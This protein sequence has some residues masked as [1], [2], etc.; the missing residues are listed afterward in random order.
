MM[1]IFC[2]HGKSQE[3]SLVLDCSSLELFWE[4]FASYDL[5]PNYKST[6]NYLESV[7]YKYLKFVDY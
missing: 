4:P 3:L 5:F 6:T 1:W 2:L 7:L